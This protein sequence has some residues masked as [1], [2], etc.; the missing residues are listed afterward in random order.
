MKCRN[1]K[2]WTIIESDLKAGLAVYHSSSIAVLTPEHVNDIS[3]KLLQIFFVE[4]KA[5]QGVI[6]FYRRSVE[7]SPA[8]TKFYG[9]FNFF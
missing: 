7:K 8:S 5:E 4:L 1:F 6:Q 2:V 3:A 9:G